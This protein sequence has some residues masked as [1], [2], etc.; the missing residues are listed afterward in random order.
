MHLSKVSMS[1]HGSTKR[2]ENYINYTKVPSELEKVAVVVLLVF[3]KPQ[4]QYL[5]SY[6][7]YLLLVKE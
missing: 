4:K 2:S 3:S 5:I 6:Q 1:I 7:F